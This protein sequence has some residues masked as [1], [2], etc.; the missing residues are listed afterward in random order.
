M[1]GDAAGLSAGNVITSQVRVCAPA[2]VTQLKWQNWHSVPWA[3]DAGWVKPRPARRRRRARMSTQLRGGRAELC[4]TPGTA[5][6]GSPSQRQTCRGRPRGRHS[7]PLRRHGAGLPHLGRQP[8]TEGR[9]GAG[10]LSPR[11]RHQLCTWPGPR[12]G[13]TQPGRAPGAR[14][15]WAGFTRLRRRS[16]PASAPSSAVPAAV[17]RH[18]LPKPPQSP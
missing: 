15:L 5:L 1:L 18:C 8:G 9:S 2:H 7:P 10:G 12:A 4:V 11:Q 13:P 3:G 16:S 14:G 17:L 6:R